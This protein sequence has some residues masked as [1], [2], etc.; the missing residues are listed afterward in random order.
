MVQDFLKTDHKIYDSLHGFIRFGSVE[1]SIIN[2][3]PFQRLHQIHQ[4]GAAFLV[5]P[6]ATHSRFQ[7]SLGV[8]EL[9]TR[10]YEKICK[11]P[12]P[13][14]FH[15]LPRKGSLDYYY[16]WLVL[17]IA[18]LCHDLGHLPFSHV[19]EKDILPNQGHE[20]WTIR[21]LKE[22]SIF[23][24]FETLKENALF[25][26]F[27]KDK[28]F[29]NDV[30]KVAVGP[31]KIMQLNLADQYVFSPWEKVLSEIITG[32][33]FGVDR[34]D[35]LLRDAKN[36]GIAYGV[37]DY[38]QMIEMIRVIPINLQEKLSLSLGID[39]SGLE[40]CES[41]L[42]ARHFMYKRVYHLPSVKAFNFH[43][44]AFMKKTIDLQELQKM[45]F[46]I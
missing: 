32:D 23:E 13:D 43:L 35:Y 18:A 9:A 27:S 41:L 1:K 26:K 45:F 29:L 17:R 38:L 15:E 20:I 21:I 14:L 2:S 42:L 30:I 11:Q 39:A 31:K 6:G 46:L 16:Y 25:Q 22:S 36:T 19:A 24:I 40:S 44:K 28:N 8:M 5:F 7:H 3:M 37:F 10:V 12:G 34:I 4:L 33:F